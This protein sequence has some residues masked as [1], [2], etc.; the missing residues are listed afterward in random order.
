MPAKCG[1]KISI[2]KL[3][4]LQEKA[5]RIANFKQHNHSLDEP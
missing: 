1:V 2:E 3:S 5:I 4:T